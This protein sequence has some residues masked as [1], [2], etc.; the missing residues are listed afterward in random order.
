MDIQDIPIT[1]KEV[2]KSEREEKFYE[3]ER[4]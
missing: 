1:D 4:V 3:R 2:A